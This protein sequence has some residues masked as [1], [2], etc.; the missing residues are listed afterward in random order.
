MKRESS[1]MKAIL[2]YVADRF[3][4]EQLKAVSFRLI[5]TC[6]RRSKEEKK[7]NILTKFWVAKLSDILNTYE[8]G[9]SD[10][11]KS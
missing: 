6:Q 1:Q 9:F 4:V 10:W 2:I 5:Q 7:K 8:K 11:M 3:S